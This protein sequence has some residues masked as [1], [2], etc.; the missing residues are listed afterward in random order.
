MV[1]Y[2]GSQ[3]PF[4]DREAIAASLALPHGQVRVVHMPTE[5]PFGAKGAGEIT[6][7][8]TAPAIT[9]AIRRAVGVRTFALPV[10]PAALKG[11][12]GPAAHRP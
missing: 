1:V 10:D 6:S 12:G 5:G 11:C 2:V 4:E 9:N 3:V 8:P 7:M